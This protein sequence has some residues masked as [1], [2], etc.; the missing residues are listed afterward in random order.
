MATVAPSIHIPTRQTLATTLTPFTVP[1]GA[2][3]V[4]IRPITITAYL[5]FS[6]GTDGGAL[7]AAYET[8]TAD[9][10]EWRAI[11]MYGSTLWFAGSGAGV[12]EITFS[13]KGL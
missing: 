3:Y 6:G 4:K 12:C 2:H 5:Q 9:V 13:A 8:F 1:A 7:G 10:S 11:H